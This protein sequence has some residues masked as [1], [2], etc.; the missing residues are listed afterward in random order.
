MKGVQKVTS[1]YP[2]IGSITL[3]VGSVAVTAITLPRQLCQPSIQ[4]AVEV[5]P[6]TPPHHLGAD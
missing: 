2:W 3:V 6:G 5:P 4:F 1:L